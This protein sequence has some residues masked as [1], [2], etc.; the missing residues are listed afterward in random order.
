MIKERIL[1][2]IYRKLYEE[3]TPSADFDKLLESGEASKPNFFMN[4]YLKEDRISEIIEEVCKKNRVPKVLRRNYSINV[5]LGAS[6]TSI[7]KRL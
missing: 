7:K 6:P 4:Y 5:F 2:D 3:A 1:F